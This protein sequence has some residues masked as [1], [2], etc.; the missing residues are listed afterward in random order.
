MCQPVNSFI[1]LFF[2]RSETLSPA[3]YEAESSCSEGTISQ[4]EEAIAPLID[5][6]Q[7][8][9]SN[10]HYG[11]TSVTKQADISVLKAN[12][13][14][15]EAINR[16]IIDTNKYMAFATSLITLIACLTIRE[17]AERGESFYTPLVYGMGLAHIS[18]L[19]ISMKLSFQ[20]KN[21]KNEIQQNNTRPSETQSLLEYA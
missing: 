2:Q 16:K 14:L 18:L 4:R 6:I 3:T 9:Q 15:I 7:P 8:S 13:A 11:S 10:Q 21:L 1:K 17:N 19:L 5:E 20:E 12:L